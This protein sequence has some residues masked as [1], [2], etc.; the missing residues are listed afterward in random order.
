[1]SATATFSYS[2]G[3]YT[4]IGEKNYDIPTVIKLTAR[5]FTNLNNIFIGSIDN[6]NTELDHKITCAFAYNKYNI[7]EDLDNN[8]L[9]IVFNL[10][11]NTT[12]EVQLIEI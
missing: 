11:D 8:K 4:I 3:D 9:T 12:L 6:V 7:I 10:Y 5:H 2:Q 1:M